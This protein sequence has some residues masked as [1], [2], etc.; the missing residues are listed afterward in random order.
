MPGPGQGAGWAAFGATDVGLVRDRNEDAF[1][2]D[3]SLGCYLVADGLGGHTGGDVA[4][5]LARDTVIEVVGAE[6][7]AL[8]A[9]EAAAVL[10]RAVNAAS[11][12]IHETARRDP[13]LWGMATTL[14]VLWIGGAGRG[15]VAHVGDSRIYR[16][17]GAGLSVLTEDHT[18][19]MELVR[20]GVMS[21]EE[22]ER[23]IAWHWLT[24]AVGFDEPLAIDGFAVDAGGADAL[25]L[26]S[27]GLSGMVDDG[28]TATVLRARAPDAEAAC[29]ALIETA[30]RN[31]GRDN[32]TVVVLY[33]RTQ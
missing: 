23:S 20:A 6:R 10:E 12:T 5:R 28:E 9:G 14:S 33:P 11:D 3:E 8:A 13:S 17:D 27:D 22:A 1:A 25:L 29:R 21:L 2:V 15:H 16:L 26:C 24:R 32:I 4:S 7:E 30:M 19:G 18:Q 31:G